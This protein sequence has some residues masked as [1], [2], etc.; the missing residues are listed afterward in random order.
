MQVGK[1]KTARGNE[2]DYRRSLGLFSLRAAL[3]YFFNSCPLTNRV[4]L[5]LSYIKGG[6]KGGNIVGK[7][8]GS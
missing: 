4:W 3:H 7:S 1:I 5:I 2:E 6:E 8:I